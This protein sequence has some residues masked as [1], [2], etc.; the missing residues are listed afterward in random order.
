M[1]ILGPVRSIEQYLVDE[2][3]VVMVCRQH[4]LVLAR[5]VALWAVWM[6]SASVINA[7]LGALTGSLVDPVITAVVLAAT[8]FAVVRVLQWWAA[9]YL[10][11]DRRVISISGLVAVRVASVP[12]SKVND[13]ILTRPFFGRLFGYGDLLLQS[14]AERTGLP[15]LTFLP[16]P[17]EAYRL[18]TALLAPD[19]VRPPGPARRRWPGA[20]GSQE[21]DTGPL[22]RFG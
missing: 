18:I 15:R 12:L 1:S 13:V 2:E 16:K 3:Q 9:R 7:F 19:E 14:A 6:L 11:T 21:D 22:P 5:P 4:P 8:A 17:R 10:V 20:R